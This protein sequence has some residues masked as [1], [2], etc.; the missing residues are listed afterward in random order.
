MQL[1]FLVAKAL[2]EGDFAKATSQVFRRRTWS[3]SRRPAR[4]G[5]VRTSR[6]EAEA[7]DRHRRR[8]WSCAKKVATTAEVNLPRFRL[9]LRRLQAAI[10]QA[11]WPARTPG[12]EVPCAEWVATLL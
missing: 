5:I 6:M 4:G 1:S 8:G 9:H 10:P 12:A 2:L 3:P 7:W 11:S